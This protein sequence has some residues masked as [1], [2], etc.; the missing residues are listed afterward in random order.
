MTATHD[1]LA[2]FHRFAKVQI[3]HAGG[4]TLEDC[5]RLWRQREET[6]AE[7][8]EADAQMDAGEFLAINEA[9]VLLRASL[10]SS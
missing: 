2:R 6:V 1:E 9:D 10:F 4:L 5:L 7:V 3:D 8:L